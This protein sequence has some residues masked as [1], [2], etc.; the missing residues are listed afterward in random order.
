MTTDEADRIVG[1]PRD[2]ELIFHCHDGIRSQAAAEHFSGLG[3]E[4]VYNVHGGIDAWSQ[5]VDSDV[6]RY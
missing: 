3:F 6:P 1:L 2:T 4:N 5:E